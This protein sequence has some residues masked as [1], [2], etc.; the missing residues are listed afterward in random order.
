M[1]ILTK[2]DV[3]VRKNELSD[4][5][6]AGCIFIHPTDTIYGIGCNAADK[7]AVEKIRQIKA[8]PK[9]PFSV[10]APSIAWIHENCEVPKHAEKWLKKLPGPFTLIFTL[11]NKK[12]IASNVNPGLTSV[13]IR[14]PDHWFHEIVKELGVPIVTTSAN[15]VGQEF[16]TSLDDLDPNIRGRLN[17]IFYEGEKKGKPSQVID[18]T[19]KEEKVLR[20]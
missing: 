7:K 5:I 12:V 3:S 19:G 18:F 13:G 15:V 10:M 9:T 20:K 2:D 11:K 1:E 16:M 6:Q 14:I 8:R 17:F 4:E